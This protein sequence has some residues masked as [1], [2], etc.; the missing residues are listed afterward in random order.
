MEDAGWKGLKNGEL[1]QEANARFEVLLTADRN[2]CFQRRFGGL[3]LAVLA[4]PTNL[5]RQVEHCVPAVRQSLAQLQPG[6]RV[7]MV[8][9]PEWPDAAS[10]M[11]QAV[12][13]DGPLTRPASASES[14]A[15][16]PM[17]SEKRQKSARGGLDKSFRGSVFF[18][19]FPG[20]N[21]LVPHDFT[22]VYSGP[23]LESTHDHRRLAC[24]P[25]RF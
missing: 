13:S 12:E 11:L 3:W 24:Y 5:K 16:Q 21:R 18:A 2:L 1:L 14:A 9:P 7:V 25:H 10:L 8:L 17:K 22:D 6:Q 15:A 4:L 23:F 20:K 19:P